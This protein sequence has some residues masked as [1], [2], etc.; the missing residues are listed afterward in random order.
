VRGAEIVGAVGV[1]I[2]DQPPNTFDR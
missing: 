1:V 2:R